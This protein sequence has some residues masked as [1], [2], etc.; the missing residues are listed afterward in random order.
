MGGMNRILLLAVPL[1]ALA[2][3][4]P[5][6]GYVDMTKAMNDTAEGQAA[7]AS[8]NALATDKRQAIAAAQAE[9]NK[10]IA[11]KADEAVVKAAQAKADEVQRTAQADFEQ[12]Q[13]ASAAKISAGLARILPKL[14]EAHHFAAIAPKPLDVAPD[15]EVTKELVDRYNAGEGAEPPPDEIAAKKVADLEKKVA[16]QDK[17]IAGLQAAKGMAANA[18]K[19]KGVTQ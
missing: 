11:E 14:R 16:D 6:T 7:I 8:I 13:S 4:T 3:C 15:L 10:R 19:P 5:R 1:L 17:K 18:Q 12:R 2:A 9:V